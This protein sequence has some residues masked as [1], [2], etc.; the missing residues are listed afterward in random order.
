MKTLREILEEGITQLAFPNI[1]KPFKVQKEVFNNNNTD[2]N[3]FPIP[4]IKN[5]VLEKSSNNEAKYSLTVNNQ[6][7]KVK[8]NKPV[9]FVIDKRGNVDGNEGCLLLP[10][11][12]RGIKGFGGNSIVENVGKT[13]EVVVYT[14]QS[15]IKLYESLIKNLRSS[16]HVVK[17]NSSE[18]SDHFLRFT[19]SCDIKY[20]NQKGVITLYDSGEDLESTVKIG[21]YNEPAVTDHN[22]DMLYKSIIE[23]FEDF[24]EY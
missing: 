14:I 3:G 18:F 16:K 24:E 20:E 21:W 23:R 13:L 7:F 10:I 12:S 19:I 2:N 9:E 17:I 5:L 15:Y 11:S 4:L 22:M 6:I 8:D 1:G